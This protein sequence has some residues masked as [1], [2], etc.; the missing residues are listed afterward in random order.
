MQYWFLFFLLI[1][2]QYGLA[3]VT[4]IGYPIFGLIVSIKNSISKDKVKLTRFEKRYIKTYKAFRKK[5]PDITDK[6]A[7]EKMIRKIILKKHNLTC[8]VLYVLGTAGVFLVYDKIEKDAFSAVL[9]LVS[10]ILCIVAVMKFAK[11]LHDPFT[12]SDAE[13]LIEKERREKSK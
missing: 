1:V 10:G 11:G 3:I 5:H 6:A 7:Q 4:L 12:P 8:L 13:E 9:G 2:G